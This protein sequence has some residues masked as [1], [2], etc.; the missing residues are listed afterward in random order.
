MPLEAISDMK[1]DSQEPSTVME[2]QEQYRLIEEGMKD[3]QP[4]YQL[5]IKLHFFKGLA[6]NEA[7][8]IIGISMDNAYSLKHRA[9]KQLK[10]KITQNRG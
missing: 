5:F 9:I 4:R 1:A 6:I 3:M 7:A 10:S 2:K 8:D